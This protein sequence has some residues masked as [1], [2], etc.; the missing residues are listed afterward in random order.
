M[1]LFFLVTGIFALFM[2]SPCFEAVSLWEKMRSYRLGTCGDEIL[3]VDTFYLDNS[4]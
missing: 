1:S 3:I 4:N 2:Q